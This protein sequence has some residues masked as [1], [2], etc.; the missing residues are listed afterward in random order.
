[1]TF[2]M[3]RRS[4]SDSGPSVH[5]T[6]H[7]GWWEYSHSAQSPNIGTTSCGPNREATCLLELRLRGLHNAKFVT[8][9]ISEPNPRVRNLDDRHRV[10]SQ[11]S[12]IDQSGGL[13]FD[14]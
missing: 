4:V 12:Q 6:A 5:P 11:G 14:V 7:S 13:T 8:L 10:D 2:I 9:G 1:V 3:S